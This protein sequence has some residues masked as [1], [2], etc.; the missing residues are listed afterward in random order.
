MNAQFASHTRR[1]I[2]GRRDVQ[3]AGERSRMAALLNGPDGTRGDKDR[4]S[5]SEHVRSG[6][7]TNPVLLV[8]ALRTLPQLVGGK[9]VQLQLRAALSLR[10]Q[11]GSVRRIGS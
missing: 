3:D 10:G 8:H 7:E 5:E 1:A 4:I 2:A 9:V 6:R 11:A